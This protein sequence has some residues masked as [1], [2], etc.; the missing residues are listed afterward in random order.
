M[1]AQRTC[2]SLENPYGVAPW[3]GCLIRHDVRPVSAELAM[4]SMALGMYFIESR[5]DFE[6]EATLAD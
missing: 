6:T 5:L 1:T 3:V 2:F 4:A